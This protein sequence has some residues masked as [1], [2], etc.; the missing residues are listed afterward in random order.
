MFVERK[1]L[2]FRG[3]DLTPQAHV[4]LARYWGEPIIYPLPE[5]GA[6][7]EIVRGVHGPHSPGGENIWHSDVTFQ[8]TPA[9]GSILKAVRLPACGG[10]TLWADMVAAYEGLTAEIK[11]ILAGLT[12][13]HDSLAPLRGHRS[14]EKAAADRDAFPFAEHPVVRIHPDTGSRILYVNHYYTTELKG[15]TQ[16]ADAADLLELLCNQAYHPE[17]QCRFR[18]TEGS[19]ALW[20]NRATQH[21]A[22]S[23]YY[24]HERV[25]ERVT[26]AGDRPS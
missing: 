24:P 18:W 15:D 26:I 6:L 2:F 19:V 5:K 10:D 25:M 13:I 8:S 20:D 9:L 16:G 1:V 22:A 3:Q 21:Y 14:F 4:D 12:A 23:D 17:Y 7:P 11:A